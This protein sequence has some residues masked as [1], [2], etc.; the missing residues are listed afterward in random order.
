M[1]CFKYLLKIQRHMGD[2]M[3]RWLNNPE[4]A[5]TRQRGID[6]KKWKDKKLSSWQG[7]AT[8]PQG[9]DS[10]VFL[11]LPRL[12]EWTALSS[13]PFCKLR[14]VLLSNGNF[15]K[16]ASWH[17]VFR[18]HLQL[19]CLKQHLQYLTMY[20]KEIRHYWRIIYPMLLCIILTL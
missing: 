6:E 14:K 20:D 9:G 11:L 17:T 7:N 5:L 1:M 13:A 16:N 4:K 18:L 3:I 8:K 10:T 19:H 12:S 15:I 2:S